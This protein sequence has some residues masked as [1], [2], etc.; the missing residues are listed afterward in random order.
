MMK[1]M[2]VQR[3]QNLQNDLTNIR[4]NKKNMPIYKHMKIVGSENCFIKL[5]HLFPCKSIVELRAEEGKIIKKTGTLNRNIAGQ[6]KKEYKQ[7]EK[8]NRYYNKNKDKLKDRHLKYYNLKHGQIVCD[9]CG[10]L[11]AK[12]HESRHE[13]TT[14]HKQQLE[15]N[16]FLSHI[17]EDIKYVSEL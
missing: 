17:E 5:H 3:V 6:T 13:K 2:L 14:I 8:Y 16:K 12:Y 7:L 15:I 4:N 10:L 9:V 11:H 1:Y